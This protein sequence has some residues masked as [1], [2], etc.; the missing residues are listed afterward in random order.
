MVHTCPRCELRFLTAAEL[1]EHLRIDH[2]V[3]VDGFERF[4]YKPLAR[5]PPSKRYL[6]LANQ[7]L[8]DDSVITLLRQLGKDG[9]LHLVV[10]AAPSTPGSDRVD[11]KG[12]ALATYRLRHA[13]DTLHEHGIDAEG[14]VGH[15]DPVH[16]VARAFEHEPADEIIVS[17]LPSGISKWLDVDLPKALEHRFG[18]PVTVITAEP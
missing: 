13:V 7:T 6:V 17:T 10:P 15:V 14:E 8:N 1:T 18:V 4:Q 3:D 9:H 11:D 2:H 16:A 5:R 12:L